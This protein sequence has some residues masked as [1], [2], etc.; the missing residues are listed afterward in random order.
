MVRI[1]NANAATRTA[2]GTLT[3]LIARRDCLIKRTET[4]RRFLEE[5]RSCTRRATRTEIKIFSVIDVGAYQAKCVPD[6]P[7]KRGGW[8]RSFRRRT[9]R[10]NCGKK[11]GIPAERAR[12][13]QRRM[14]LCV[15]RR[16][17]PCLWVRIPRLSM[18]PRASLQTHRL[19]VTL[20]NPAPAAGRGR[21]RGAYLIP[22]FTAL[23]AVEAIPRHTA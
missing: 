20:Y 21:V 22:R 5:A 9:G 16:A 10:R 2:E 1:N 14:R 15:W 3:E 13:R 12:S 8:I 19:P 4:Y 11:A 17:G 23:C 18:Q 7:K 6:T